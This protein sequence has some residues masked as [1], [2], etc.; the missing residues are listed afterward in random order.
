[1]F[2]IIFIS[3]SSSLYTPF[4]PSY[5]RHYHSTISQFHNLFHSFHLSLFPSYISLRLC[6][7]F[8]LIDIIIIIRLWNSF[9][10]WMMISYRNAISDKWSSKC[11]SIILLICHK[12]IFVCMRIFEDVNGIESFFIPRLMA[13]FKGFLL[14]ISE[15]YY[16]KDWFDGQIFNKIFF[17]NYWV[18]LN[19]WY[20]SVF[21]TFQNFILLVKFKNF[22]FFKFAKL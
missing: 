12:F 21:Q 17:L 22:K 15:I 16:E 4:I 1:M 9:T 7:F 3:S 8:I 11:S 10:E 13:S 5:L 14:K 19:F 18:I 6:L 2:I 20:L